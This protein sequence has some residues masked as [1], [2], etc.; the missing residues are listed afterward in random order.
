VG[1]TPTWSPG[2]PPWPAPRLRD[3]L[4]R[5]VERWLA[6]LVFGPA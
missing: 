4:L 6:H 3:K 5:R 1:R 2:S